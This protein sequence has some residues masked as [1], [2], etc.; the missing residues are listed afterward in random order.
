ML[1]CIK[2]LV[3][4]ISLFILLCT[5]A[6]VSTISLIF[7]NICTTVISLYPPVIFSKN[8]DCSPFIICLTLSFSGISTSHNLHKLITSSEYSNTVS[9][10]KCTLCSNLAL[11]SYSLSCPAKC[12]FKYSKN[13]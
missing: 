10:S 12:V 13:L 5:N 8:D 1:L 9:F 7:P 11:N 3:S 2:V 4:T 6:L